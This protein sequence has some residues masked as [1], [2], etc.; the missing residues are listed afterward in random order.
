MRSVILERDADSLQK[1]KCALYITILNDITLHLGKNNNIFSVK[2]TAKVRI[3]FASF[4]A[5]SQMIDHLL[6]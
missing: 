3:I 1:R 2:L 4:I 6:K 5:I